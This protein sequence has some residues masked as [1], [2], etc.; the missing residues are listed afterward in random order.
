MY[1]VGGGLITYIVGGGRKGFNHIYCG[2]GG[3]VHIMQAHVL[4]Y[5]KNIHNMYLV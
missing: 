5:T 4:V 3:G 2:G 1:I